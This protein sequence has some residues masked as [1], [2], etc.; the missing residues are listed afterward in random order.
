MPDVKKQENKVSGYCILPVRYSKIVTPAD[1]ISW[2]VTGVS[3]SALGTIDYCITDHD[4]LPVS[5]QFNLGTAV[6]GPYY[7]H[8]KGNGEFMALGMKEEL[9]ISAVALMFDEYLTIEIIS[10]Y[11]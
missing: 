1:A 7:F 6:Y 11:S 9:E 3:E 10:F 5:I 8:Y 2:P 4:G